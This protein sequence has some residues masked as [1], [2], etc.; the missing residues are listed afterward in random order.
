MPATA[1]H[2][3]AFEIPD[4]KVGQLDALLHGS[5]ALELIDTEL[6]GRPGPDGLPVRTVLVGL[7]LSLH[8]HRSASLADVCSVLLD[9]LRAPARGWLGVPDPGSLDDHGRHAFTRRIYRSFDRL[10]TALDP[11]RCDRRRRLPADEAALAVAAWED[12]DA[13]RMR[14]RA[15]LQEISDRLVLTTVHLAHRR[16]LFKGWRGDISVD[17]TP[18]PAWHHEPCKQP[19]PAGDI[20]APHTSSGTSSSSPGTPHAPEPPRNPGRSSARQPI[21]APTPFGHHLEHA[22]QTPRSRPASRLNG[23]S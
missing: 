22:P 15:V 1:G 19:T 18:V 13:E 16:G 7:L 3:C 23:I 21:E 20:P 8:Y 5:G 9:E 10:T 17:T 2:G 4:S 12:T 14:R 11:F 6:A